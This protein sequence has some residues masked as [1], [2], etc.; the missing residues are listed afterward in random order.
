[1]KKINSETL[2]AELQAD[3]RTIILKATR[4]AHYPVDVLNQQ[5]GT[6]GWSVAQVLEHMN[7]YARYYIKAIE[8]G[9]HM[10]QT[11]PRPTFRPGWLGNYFTNIMKPGA[12][13]LIGNKMKT[14][15]N[16]EPSI[17]PDAKAV[18]QEF[19]GHQHHL[20][21][22]LPIAGMA[23]LSAIRIPISISR[24][25]KLKLG[26]TLQFFVAHEQRHMIQVMNVLQSV[27]PDMQHRS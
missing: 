27:A 11:K 20:L 9:L 4:L 2:V 23:N 25:I 21:T 5:P 7:I 6:G 1:M 13:E 15:K 24:F 14:F 19:L 12:G 18:L 22:L 17:L 10:N 26:D 8:D 3:V 16:A